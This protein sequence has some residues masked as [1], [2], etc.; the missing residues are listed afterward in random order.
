MGAIL[1]KNHVIE[2]WTALGMV[3]GTG[4]ADQRCPDREWWTESGY[5][6]P[7]AQDLE[8]HTKDFDFMLQATRSQRMT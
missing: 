1:Y 6:V 4:H 2:M 5:A 3:W 7:A 8:S